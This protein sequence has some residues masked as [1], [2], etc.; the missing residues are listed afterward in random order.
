LYGIGLVADVLGI[1][2]KILEL[3]LRCLYSSTALVQ[4]RERY[5]Y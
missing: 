1:T 3:P 5:M 4:R 2:T